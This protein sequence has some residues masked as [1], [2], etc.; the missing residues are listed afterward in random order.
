M[1]R[2]LLAVIAVLALWLAGCAQPGPG[3][4]SCGKLTLAHGLVTPVAGATTCLVN[5]EC[6]SS[7]KPAC[8]APSDNLCAC[9][10]RDTAGSCTAGHCVWHPDPGN[11]SCVCVPG[12]IMSCTLPTGTGT[13]SCNAGGTGWNPCA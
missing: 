9:T 8:A 6:N 1:N 3:G 13:Q 4:A 12:Q 2:G 7:P 5:S 10:S 11:L